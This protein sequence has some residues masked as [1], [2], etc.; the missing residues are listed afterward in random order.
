MSVLGVSLWVFVMFALLFFS[1]YRYRKHSL[2]LFNKHLKLAHL[3]L[4]EKGF[5]GIGFAQINLEMCI[6]T[7]YFPELVGWAKLYIC[8]AEKLHQEVLED[9]VLSEENFTFFLQ[10]LT[11]SSGLEMLDIINKKIREQNP[12]LGWTSCEFVA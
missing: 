3:A 2:Y 4:S 6:C 11:F 1:V 5:E 10:E 12:R 9:P 8:Q 7:G